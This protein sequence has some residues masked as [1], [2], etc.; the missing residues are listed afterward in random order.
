DPAT[1]PATAEVA[2]VPGFR[3]STAQTGSR[4]RG[5]GNTVVVLSSAIVRRALR[6]SPGTAFRISRRNSDLAFHFLFIHPFGDR[7]RTDLPHSHNGN[8]GKGDG[9]QAGSAGRLPG[10]GIHFGRAA[11]DLRRRE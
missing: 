8:G 11:G 7:L 2:V 1:Q 9:P 4:A 6:C 5:C 10:T 3:T